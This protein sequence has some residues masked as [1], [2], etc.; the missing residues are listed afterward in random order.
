MKKIN[1]E[2]VKFMLTNKTCL[3]T[4]IGLCYSFVCYVMMLF[5]LIYEVF[6]ADENLLSLLCVLW[7]IVMIPVVDIS[8]RYIFLGQWKEKENE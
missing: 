1:W 6:W 3:T 4:Y 8:T 5:I 2:L 7:I